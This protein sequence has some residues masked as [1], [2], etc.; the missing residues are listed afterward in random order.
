MSEDVKPATEPEDEEL[1]GLGPLARIAWRA[2]AE[3]APTALALMPDPR[4]HFSSLESQAEMEED[5]IVPQLQGPDE[6]GESTIAKAGRIRAAQ[7]MAREMVIAEMLRPPEDLRDPQYED[8]DRRDLEAFTTGISYYLLPWVT[9]VPD[10]VEDPDLWEEYQDRL[11]EKLDAQDQE[12]TRQQR[13]QQER[14]ALIA[15]ARVYLGLSD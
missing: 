15:R 6:P 4:A 13:R 1:A 8:L 5:R 2:W 12:R 3:E 9:T 10:P 7:S 14:Q 11:V